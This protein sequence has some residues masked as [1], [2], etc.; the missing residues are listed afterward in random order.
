[1]PAAALDAPLPARNL[2]ATAHHR[3]RPIERAI[4][5]VIKPAAASRARWRW[6]AASLRTYLVA[7]TLLATVPIA[8]LMS[9]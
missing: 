3:H 5:T 2:P 4:E 7:I 9:Y 8:A 6:P 1:M